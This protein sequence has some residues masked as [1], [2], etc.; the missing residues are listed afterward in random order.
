LLYIGVLLCGIFLQLPWCV[1]L[2]TFSSTSSSNATLDRSAFANAYVAG[3]KEDLDLYGNQYSIILSIFTA[4][5]VVGQIPH[6]LILQKV[7]PRLWLPFTL[8]TWSGLTM[9][10][11]A[12]KTYTQLCFVRFLQGLFESSLYSG[13]I[14]ILGSWYKPLEIAKRTSIFTA[15]GQ[16]GSMFAGV[17]MA[18]MSETMKGKH[19][20][21]GWQWV[22]I[23]DGAM[24]IPFAIFGILFFPDL[25]ESTRAPY[26]SK[27]EIQLAIDRLPPKRN[28]GHHIGAK[29]LAKRLFLSPNLYVL[30]SY[31]IVG[32]ALE[33]FVVQGL[34]LLWIKENASQFPSSAA[35]TYPL[36]IQAVAVVSNIGAG[37]IIDITNRRIPMALLASALQLMVSSMLLVPNSST[38]GIFVAFYLSGTSYIVNPIM[39][40]WAST[41]CQRGGDD[42]ARAVILYVMSMVQAILYTFWGVVLYPAT[43]APYW[44]NGCIAMIAVVF[45]FLG[46]TALMQWV[47]QMLSSV[48]A[49][50]ANMIIQL[51]M[52]SLRLGV[53]NFHS[54]ESENVEMVQVS[55]NLA[56]NSTV[57][58]QRVE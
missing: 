18:A 40:G 10:S 44:K 14:Y 28:D 9:C 15:V 37:Y 35:N 25:P 32:S 51:D 31:S 55:E 27:E 30:A 52:R 48:H 19:A 24:G 1:S 8:L 47:G 49:I 33:A 5:N 36:G 45:S 13:T 57:S 54:A 7:A 46:L 4:G 6:A 16:I 58:K 38:T 42:A 50:I 3:L 21:S 2:A 41:I 22:F 34:F 12:C 29:S 11:A 39:Y 53:G 20:L 43:D 17:M 23:V 26:L 56:P